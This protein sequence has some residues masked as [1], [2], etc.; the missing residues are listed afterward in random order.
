MGEAPQFQGHP[1]HGMAWV[2][3]HDGTQGGGAVGG[4][5]HQRI[6]AEGAAEIALREATGEVWENAGLIIVFHPGAVAGAA[7][8]PRDFRTEEF[9]EPS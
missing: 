1:S 3:F 8:K 9:G 4:A 5:V 6:K 2:E 7:E